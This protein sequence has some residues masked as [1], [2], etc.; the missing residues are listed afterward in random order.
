MRRL[1]LLA[2]CA[3]LGACGGGPK[4]VAPPAPQPGSAPVSPSAPV[5][6]SPL[7]YRLRGPLVYE[8]FRYDSLFYAA[9][10]GAPQ[11]SG[12]R[13]IL[14]IRPVPGRT[15]ETEVR[16]DSVEALED[17]RLERPAVDSSLG[18]RWQML[19]GPSG[20][21]GPLLGGRRLIIPGQFEPLIRLLFPQLP[22]D[23]LREGVTWSDSASFRIQLDAF[24]A[25]ETAV[26][27]SRGGAGRGAGREAG[28]LT[29]DAT[30]Q[31]RRTGTASQGGQTMSLQGTGARRLSYDF[32]PE[33]WV[34]GLSARDSLE[35]TVTVGAGGQTIP[36]RWR[37]TLIARLRDVP[38]R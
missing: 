20:P 34:S 35:V 19:L 1:T 8:V 18:T 11:T 2:A 31:L 37:S 21:Q 17:S 33:G 29:V 9:M 36:V 32:S 13:A 10:P 26:R 24:E 6:A 15:L 12:K 7:R 16:L 4:P 28:S 30:E 25:R 38:P 23:G 14:V 22:A 5:T 27:A 3:I